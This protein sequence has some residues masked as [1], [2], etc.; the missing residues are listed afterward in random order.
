MK[1][2]DFIVTSEILSLISEID[3][4]KG[5][6]KA[7]KNLKPELMSSLKLVAS[8]ESIGSSTRI[9]GVKLTDSEIEKLLKGLN[10]HSF[11]S[12]DEE[13]V[14]G[15]S[16]AMGMIFESFADIDL[17]ENHIKQLH[18]VLLKF[19]SKDVRHRGQ[20]KKFPNHVEAFDRDGVSIGVVF[21]TATPFETPA[22]MEELVKWAHDNLNRSETHPLIA[23]AV[24]IVHFLA[25][26]PFQDG[27]G[28]LSRILTTL[29]LLRSGYE[30]IP[31]SSLEK[32]V[33]ANKSDYYLA[34]RQTQGDPEKNMSV[35]IIFFLKMMKK[36]K[37]EL[38][39]KLEKEHSLMRLPELSI[40]ILK[41]IKERGTA[42]ISEIELLTK[43]NR[44]TIKAHL[45]QLVKDEL[46]E[47]IGF[48]KG[49]RYRGR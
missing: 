33:E 49:A 3:E 1:G 6:W 21:E 5:S 39:E 29:L 37:D 32:V 4:F 15:Y 16:E 28:R 45:R 47:M 14:A 43:A 22:K 27:N 25:I 30:Y 20:Y 42:T 41:E 2:S 13:E 10:P 19:S 9:E 40:K 12:R 26:H 31:Y 46:L 7:L 17:T 8:I 24:F 38:L 11:S 36:Q 35:W 18:Q 44:N 34:L 23:I 48:G